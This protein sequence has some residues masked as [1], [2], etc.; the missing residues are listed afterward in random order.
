[1]DA[2]LHRASIVVLSGR[3]LPGTPVDAYRR[4]TELSHG[5]GAQVVLDAAGPAFK[6]ALAAGPEVVTPNRSELASASGSR[7]D[8]LMEGV[9]ACRKLEARGARL[10]VATIGADGAAATRGTEAWRARPNF[11]NAV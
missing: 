10:V 9:G 5:H 1:M 2:Y 7:C 8:T 3:L 4:L 11:S 6:N